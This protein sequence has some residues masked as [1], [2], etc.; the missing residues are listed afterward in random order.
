M[1]G[2]YALT[3]TPEEI[4][5]FVSVVDFEEVFPAR[6]NIAPTQPILVVAA[7][8]R[9]PGSNLPARSALLARWGFLPGWVKDPKEFPLLFNA[10]SEQAE[11]KASF[12]AAMRHRRVLI[13]ATG[14]Y[15]WRRPPKESG[16]KPQAYYI[17]PRSG[18]VIAFGGL[19]ETWAS[20]DGSEVDTAAILTTRANATLRGIHERMPVV[21]GQEDFD[22]WLEC[23]RQEP[24]HVADLLKPAQEDLFEAIPVSDLVNTVSNMGPDVQKPV[25]VAMPDEKTPTRKSASPDP[26]QMS[27]F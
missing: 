25:A 22:R 26:N 21:I 17:R 24:R 23:K 7:S 1:C 9:Q 15:E 8:D 18:G 4:L 3:A 5:Q 20:A 12:R 16:V 2:R 27:L 13:P 11:T 6:F 10:R 14:F 19:M